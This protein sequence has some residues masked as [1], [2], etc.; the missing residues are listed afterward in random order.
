MM[1]FL[2]NGMRKF[3]NVSDIG[4]GNN[5]ETDENVIKRMQ[6]L[7]TGDFRDVMP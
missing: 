7:I 3:K 2:V 1:F 6:S 4:L 5:K